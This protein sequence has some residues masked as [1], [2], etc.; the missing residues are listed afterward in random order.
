MAEAAARR[1]RKKTG[2]LAGG[3]SVMVVIMILVGTVSVAM[4]AY[5]MYRQDTIEMYSGR[6][7]AIAQTV[8]AA[9]D[10]DGMERAIDTREKDEQWDRIKEMADQAAVDTEAKYLYIVDAHP[11]ERADGKYFVYYAEGWNPATGDDPLDFLY[12]ETAEIYMT[13]A[14]DVIKTG[15]AAKTGVYDTEDFGRLVTAYAPVKDG[16]GIVVGFVGVDISMETALSNVHNFA[17]RTAVIVGV[18]IV[19]F[20]LISIRF[21]NR[22]VKRPV[23]LVSAAAEKI[24][25]GDLNVDVVYTSGDEIG[26]LFDSFNRMIESTRRQIAV[27]K[28][29]SDGDLSVL[30]E[31]RSEH[32]E[33]AFALRS[34]VENLRAMLDVFRKSADSLRESAGQIAEGSGHLALDASG[35]LVSIKGIWESVDSITKNT[36]E[37]EEKAGAANVLIAGMAKK[38]RQGS[39]QIERVVEA[40]RAIQQSS[41]AIAS[42]AGS[43]ESIA[44]Q[45]KILALNAS[46]EAARAGQ[47]GRGFAVVADEV[48]NLAAKSSGSAQSASVLIEDS[49]RQVGEGVEIARQ[50]ASTFEEIV[51]EIRKSEKMLTAIA[52]ASVQQSEDIV[53]INADIAGMGDMIRSTTAAAEDSA[54]IGETLTER[55][56][57]LAEALSR[58]HLGDDKG[59]I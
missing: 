10:A 3:L 45:T 44:F 30:V 8:A 26:S 9:V 25:V 20:I 36:R 5:W 57:Q 32:D 34:T 39:E 58:Y 33:L 37:N 23:E 29:I 31:P 1:G 42:V 11:V 56:R 38:A 17:I 22:R 47:F 49:L 51:A 43:I 19:V 40:V 55:A 28:R 52:D 21:I 59:E 24:A 4:I 35:E 46:V 27:F 2:S 13:E 14:Y 15:R 12:E 53:R 41:E 16:D 50:A 54:K 6:V 18:L 7:E 48:S